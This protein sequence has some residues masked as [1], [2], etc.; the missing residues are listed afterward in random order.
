MARIE[1]AKVRKAV[2]ELLQQAILDCDPQLVVDQLR[3]VFAAV[4][5]GG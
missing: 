4:E 1:E 3:R 2:E 5:G